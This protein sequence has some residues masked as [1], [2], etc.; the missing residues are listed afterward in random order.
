MTNQTHGQ[1][2]EELR[3]A[4][5]EGRS[6][7]LRLQDKGI[8]KDALK[9]SAMLALMSLTYGHPRAPRP[10]AREGVIAFYFHF[11]LISFKVEPLWILKA[12]SGTTVW[13]GLNMAWDTAVLAS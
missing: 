1:G 13:E 3:V 7:Y 12:F 2:D 10:Q 5:Q 9:N 11:L 4:N 8:R 6:F